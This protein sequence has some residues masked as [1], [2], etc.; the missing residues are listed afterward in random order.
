[1]PGSFSHWDEFTQEARQSPLHSYLAEE[2]LQFASHAK[3]LHHQAVGQEVIAI[4]FPIL[5]NA[6]LCH[7]TKLARQ[8]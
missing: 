6:Q 8:C 1:M 4:L 2:P 5:N 7:P 3:E